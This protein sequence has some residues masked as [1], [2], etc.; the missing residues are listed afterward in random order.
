[1]ES[2]LLPQRRQQFVGRFDHHHVAGTRQHHCAGV[3]GRGCESLA[4]FG[5]RHHVALAKDER[6]GYL[7]LLERTSRV[8]QGRILTASDPTDQR[9]P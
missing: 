8:S 7:D 5:W 3:R 2:G 1:M 4:G 9:L 6:R